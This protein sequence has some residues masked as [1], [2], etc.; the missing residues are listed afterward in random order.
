MS[1]SDSVSLVWGPLLIGK[2][3][4]VGSSKSV[5]FTN[6][7]RVLNFWP[8]V[9]CYIGP[10][11]LLRA[12][13]SEGS[14]AYKSDCVHH[15]VGCVIEYFSCIVMVPFPSLAD[16]VHMI[17]STQYVWT[18]LVSCHQDH[19]WSCRHE[20]PWGGHVLLWPSY[21][22]TLVVQSFYCRRIWTSESLPLN[23]RFAPHS[24]VS[25][26]S[27]KNKPLTLVIFILAISGFIVGIC[28][29]VDVSLAGT[30][31][32]LYECPLI[33]PSAGISTLCDF[34]ITFAVIKYMWKSGFRRQ[35]SVIQDLAIVCINTGAFT[36]TVATIIGITY[37]AQDHSYW[38][39]AAGMLFARS[40]VNSMLAVLNARKSIRDRD[41]N[42]HALTTI[43]ATPV[44]FRPSSILLSPHHA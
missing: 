4:S 22:I 39:S 35:R 26:V 19:S 15:H 1:N 33:L 10:V 43:P 30:I 32:S 20:L 3:I 13:V 29:T 25:T 5:C 8:N 14:L 11:D 2:D 27:A 6:L 7:G 9:R 34:F 42:V 31:D 16:T 41:V 17:G 23:R 18:L 37:L 12:L 21:L 44:P 28:Y 24:D 40:Y 36:C 38:D